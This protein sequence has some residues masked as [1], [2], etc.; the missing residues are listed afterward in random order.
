MVIYEGGNA[1]NQARSLW[2]IELARTKWHSALVNWQRAFRIRHITS[3][4]YLGLTPDHQVCLFHKDKADFDS[5]AFT[6]LDSKVR[7]IRDINR[8]PDE[9]VGDTSF[10]RMDSW[11]SID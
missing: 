6:L 11:H 9:S 3:G 7:V 5:T 10:Y 2:R 1:C 8:L 4:R